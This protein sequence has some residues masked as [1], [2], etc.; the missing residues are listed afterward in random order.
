MFTSHDKR[1]VTVSSRLRYM[2]L[3]CCVMALVMSPVVMAQHPSRT[4]RPRITQPVKKT[5]TTNPQ[6]PKA[7]RKGAKG[8]KV[9]RIT[10]QIPQAN[11]H[12][13]NK[14]FLAHARYFQYRLRRQFCRFPKG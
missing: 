13:S 6:P 1:H 3:A 4:L 11:R 10:P 5:V 9:S 2:L 7:A 8:P 12:Q 14:V